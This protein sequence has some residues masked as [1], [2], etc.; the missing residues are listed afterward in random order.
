MMIDKIKCLLYQLVD[1]SKLIKEYSDTSKLSEDYRVNSRILTCACVEEEYIRNELEVHLN[2]YFGL[3]MDKR[4][5][6][7]F[8]PLHS[9]CIRIKDEYRD[10]VTRTLPNFHYYFI[11]PRG[12]SRNS[13]E[14]IRLM[15]LFK[16]VKEDTKDRDLYSRH[17]GLSEITQL[18]RLENR[19]N[20]FH[21]RDWLKGNHV[22]V[23][24]V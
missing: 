22:E 2:F 12:V 18:L 10:S 11:I 13:E 16:K 5:I 23:E 15:D 14:F 17:I 20:K 24:F 6:F 3:D 19:H 1:V 4:K 8:I 9:D 21:T 7:G